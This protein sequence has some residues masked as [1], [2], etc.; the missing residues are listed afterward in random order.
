MLRELP[1]YEKRMPYKLY[2]D[3]LFT[4]AILLR[5]MR[6]SD[7]FA[8]GTIRDNRLPKGMPLPGKQSLRKKPRGEHYSILDRESGITFARWIDNN[9]V[10]EASTCFGV[11]PVS[12]VRRF[13][14]SEKK[15]VQVP[16]PSLIGKYN[17]SMGGTDLMDQNVARYR[18]AIRSKKWWWCIFSWMLDISMNNAW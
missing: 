3:D 10:T 14:R 7:I 12:S 1:K 15:M 4:S 5:D 8:T 17:D 16:R 9:I 2:T 11:E 6:N 13:C 18:I